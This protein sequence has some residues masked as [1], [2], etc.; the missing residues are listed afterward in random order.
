MCLDPIIRNRDIGKR[1]VMI[2][3]S[4]GPMEANEFG[5]ST[6]A[7]SNIGAMTAV[8]SMGLGWVSSSNKGFC[9]VRTAVYEQSM[10]FQSGNVV[11]GKQPAGHTVRH[12]CFS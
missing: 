7:V 8:D 9:V 2:S 12:A 4:V 1:L 10:L 5:G 6:F 11:V 3:P